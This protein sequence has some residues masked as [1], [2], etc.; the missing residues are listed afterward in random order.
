MQR[1]I[2]FI[3]LSFVAASILIAA[4]NSVKSNSKN[5]LRQSIIIESKLK[6]E[7]ITYTGDSVTMNSYV[8]YDENNTGKHPA[9]LVVHEWWGLTDYP[10]FRA[11]ELAKLGYVAMAIDIYGNG[12][13]ADNPDSA[14]KFALAFYK[15]PQKAKTRLDA[16]IAKIKTYSQVDTANIAAIG[17]CF[18]GSL[19]LN[20]VRLGDAD[21]KGVVCFHGSP[22]GSFHGNPS[23]GT[24]LK[25]ELLKSKILV[26][27]GS[28]DSYVPQ[29]DV[30]QFKKQMD[31]IG[32]AYTV[33]IY[34]GSTHA[35]T[36]PQATELG[37]KFNMPIA[38]NE[39]ADTASWKD[40][41]I[42]FKEL[43]K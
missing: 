9:I 21:L 43:F 26:C 22:I 14:A 20:S 32:A 23:G 25:K 36:N 29:K 24:P 28:D 35:F 16:A 37:K 27:H 10:K 18:G 12:K 34:P 5:T 19:L 11:K 6:E 17:Y 8:V 38:Y 13:I 3:F 1:F 39:A 31:S 30:D 15:N 40:M 33:K 42:F 7:N 41:L 2:S 4:N